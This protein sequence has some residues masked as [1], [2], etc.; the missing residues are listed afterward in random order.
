MD[1]HVWSVKELP[2]PWE[3][4]NF[5]LILLALALQAKFA[6]FF[7]PGITAE[8]GEFLTT[9]VPWVLFYFVE[10]LHN[11][12]VWC[13]NDRLEL[14]DAGKGEKDLYEVRLIS[15]TVLQSNAWYYC[16]ILPPLIVVPS[17]NVTYM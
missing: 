13:Q 14:L 10:D 8:I 5:I 7:G 4:C 16:L 11:V 6:S 3:K 9:G 1:V 12:K 15:N 2:E 17:V